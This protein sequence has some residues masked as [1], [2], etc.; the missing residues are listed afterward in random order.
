MKKGQNP[1]NSSLAGELTPLPCSPLQLLLSKAQRCSQCLLRPSLLGTGCMQGVQRRWVPP[2]PTCCSWG[3][4]TALP[5]GV[6]LLFIALSCSEAVRLV[7]Q[8]AVGLVGWKG[9]SSVCLESQSQLYP[10]H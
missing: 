1:A 8:P 5:G 9:H 6:K 7:E 10:P 2:S 3:Q 4:K